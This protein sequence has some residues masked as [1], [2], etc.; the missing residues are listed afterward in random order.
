MKNRKKDIVLVI[1]GIIFIVLVV[2]IGISLTPKTRMLKEIT[3]ALNPVLKEKNQSM[4]LHISTGTGENQLQTDA[5][6]YMLTEDKKYFVVEVSEFPIYIADNLLVLKNGKIFEIAEKEQEEKSDYKKLFARIAAI[7]K[8]VDFECEKSGQEKLYIVD[9]AEEEMDALLNFLPIDDFLADSIEK[10]QL[11]LAVRDKKLNRIELLAAVGEDT[12]AAEI[13]MLL[14]DFKVLARGE[15]Q[16]P[17]IV[18]NSIENVD[19]DSLFSLTEDMY[20]LIKAV[21]RFVGKEAFDGS[22]HMN[23]SCGI[24]NIN[25]TSSLKELQ[26]GGNHDLGISFD[27]DA[28]TNFISLICMEGNISC[29]NENGIFIYQLELEPKTMKILAQNMIPELVNYTLDFTK[30]KAK[31]EV[32]KDEI[33]FVKLEIQ[34]NI[35][36]LISKVP[37]SISVEVNFEQ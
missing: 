16:I 21:I 15:Y 14:S 28:V 30:G 11:K 1:A 3:S 13:F 22:V 32:E 31:I 7:Y 20:G 19:R 36:I 27:M 4:K 35:D 6:L 33:A 5:G 34:G 10:V 2:Y 23:A 18:K 29:N 8:A 12:N 9:V 17:E 37:A 25:H 24:L 26:T